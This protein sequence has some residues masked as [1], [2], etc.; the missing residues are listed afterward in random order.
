MRDTD[1][2]AF[3]RGTLPAIGLEWRGFRRVHRQVC[4]RLGRRLAALG[5]ADLQAYRVY[6]GAD[7]AEWSRLDEL[8]RISITRFYRDRAVFD[9][10]RERLLPA[11]AQRAATGR[12]AGAAGLERRLRRGRGALTRWRCSGTSTSRRAFAFPLPGWGS[13]LP[14]PTPT[15]ARWNA[16]GARP[17]TQRR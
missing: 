9:A 17:T 4:K 16:R 15:R 11:L 8:C 6:L 12:R 10:L 1:C 2:I 5:L 14:P 3:L 13:R 7:A